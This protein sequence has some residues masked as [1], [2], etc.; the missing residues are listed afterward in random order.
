M[1]LLEETI[2]VFGAKFWITKAL[3]SYDL[4]ESVLY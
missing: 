3:C 1:L 2:D 4:L